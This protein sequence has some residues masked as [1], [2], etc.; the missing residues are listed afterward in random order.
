MLLILFPRQHAVGE[1]GKR[2]K[3]LLRAIG[4]STRATRKTVNPFPSQGKNTKFDSWVAYMSVT[5]V[6]SAFY[7]VSNSRVF[8]P[9]A[10]LFCKISP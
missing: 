10:V 6:K 8:L 2:G 3:L 1:G 9:S 7:H 5:L 4:L